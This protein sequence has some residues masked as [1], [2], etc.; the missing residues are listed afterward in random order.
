MGLIGLIK[1]PIPGGPGEPRRKARAFYVAL[2][3]KIRDLPDDACKL[4]TICPHD[5]FALREG[6]EKTTLSSKLA[7]AGP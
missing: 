5:D 3:D 4:G 1:H 2:R 7:N 6:I